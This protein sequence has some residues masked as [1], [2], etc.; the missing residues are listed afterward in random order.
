MIRMNQTIFG[1]NGHTACGCAVEEKLNDGAAFA[2]KR[3]ASVD[4]GGG[5]TLWFV[6]VP[7]WKNPLCGC[8]CCANK[9]N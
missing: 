3:K 6:F 1:R 2:S 4:G 8:V 7:N 9:F 5:A